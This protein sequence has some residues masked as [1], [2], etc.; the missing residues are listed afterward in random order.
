MTAVAVY[1]LVSFVASLVFYKKAKNRLWRVINATWA[2][3]SFL[4]FIIALSIV[5][6]GA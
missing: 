5:L 1:Q 4:G 3:L 6:G 2:A